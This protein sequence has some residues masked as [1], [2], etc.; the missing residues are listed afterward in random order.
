MVLF[1]NNRKTIDS[2]EHASAAEILGCFSD[3]REMLSRLALLITGDQ[4]TAARSVVNACDMTLQ[5]HSPFRDWLTEWAKSAT[6]TSAI[7]HCAGAIRACE[8][9]YKGRRCT[10]TQHW[11]QGEERERTLDFVLKTDPAIVIAA[12]DPLS[13]AVLVLRL[14][15]RCSVQDCV[16]RLNVCRAAVVAANCQ[17]MTWLDD[18][19]LNKSPEQQ[20]SSVDT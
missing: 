1:H 10:H 12:L 2:R 16:V 19:Q 7:Y 9:T 11:S 14:A 17:A 3:E 4:A 15:I 8:A 6:I 5:G 20:V 13:R 18:M